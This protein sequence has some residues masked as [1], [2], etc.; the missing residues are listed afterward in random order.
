MTP[1]LVV[2][3]SRF[4][5][6]WEVATHIADRLRVR[7][8][9]SVEDGL[10]VDGYDAV[11]LGSGVYDGSWTADANAFV[12]SQA[13]RLAHKPVW[14]FSLGSFGDRHRVIGRLLHKEPK[15]IGEF[16]QAIHPRDYRVFAGVIDLQHRPAWA[17]LQFQALGG[18]DGDNRCWP[19]IDGW[20]DPIARALARSAAPSDGGGPSQASA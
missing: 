3:A 4:S 10:S 1:V 14:L 7:G 6:T 15:E 5:S 20:A 17:R 18:R 19:D 2:Y 9:C 13:E 12:R 11:V 8:W 16:E